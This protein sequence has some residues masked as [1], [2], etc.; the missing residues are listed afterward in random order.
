MGSRFASFRASYRESDL[1]IG[2]DPPSYSRAMED[3]AASRVRS[4]R[5]GLDAY[6]AQRPDFL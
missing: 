5:L 3:R 2:V 6:I 1:W 4:L